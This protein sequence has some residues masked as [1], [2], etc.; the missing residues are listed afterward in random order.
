MRLRPV[1]LSSLRYRHPAQ[2][3]AVHPAQAERPPEEPLSPS[4]PGADN[5]GATNPEI[6]FRGYS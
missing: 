4:G 1:T 2:L 6:S 5:P 3:D